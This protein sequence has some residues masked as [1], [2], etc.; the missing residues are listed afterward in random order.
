MQFLG[1]CKVPKHLESQG[2]TVFNATLG[3][4]WDAQDS[5]GPSNLCDTQISMGGNR[6]HETLKA[7]WDTLDSV[8][9]SRPR[10]TLKNL[11]DT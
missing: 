3:P 5:V 6:L 7:L 9:R 10:G 4:L 1:L 8:G 11:W 2:H